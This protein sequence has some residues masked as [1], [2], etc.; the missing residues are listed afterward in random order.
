MLDDPTFG[1]TF[2]GVN[3]VVMQRHALAFAAA[4][5]GNP[6]LYR[7]RD[8]WAVHERF[9]LGDEHFDTAD[10]HLVDSLCNGGIS[11]GVLAE[12][13]IRLEP[14]RVLIVSVR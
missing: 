4:G 13:A 10:V 7:G 11:D 6:D 5:L 14:L 1:W 2:E 9:G 8:L 12:L 3:R